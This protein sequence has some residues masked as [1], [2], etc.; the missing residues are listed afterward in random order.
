MSELVQ[1]RQ[2]IKA[3]ETIKKITHAMRIISMST[4][5]RLRAQ[6]S[7]LEEYK[8]TLKSLFHI[9]QEKMTSDDQQTTEP[10]PINKKNLLIIVSSQKGLCGNFNNIL[11]DFFE[12]HYPADNTL[13]IITVGKKADEYIQPRQKPLYKFQDFNTNSVAATARHI[14]E[15]IAST[16]SNYD[17]VTILSNYPK[18]FFVQKP[19]I[20]TVVPLTPTN[21]ELHDKELS[22]EYELEEDANVLLAH[23]KQL[24]MYTTL[25]EA[26]VLSLI[27]EQAARFIAMDNSSR[28]AG[29][30][31][32][33]MKLRYNKTRQAKITRELTDLVGGL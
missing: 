32:D 29:N 33:E 6:Q 23:C 28:N 21:A 19:R 13:E 20:T 12:R 1:L 24:L 11:F 22:G 16:G 17:T 9:I 15:I 25:Y 26:L 10:T 31:L 5:A 3:V 8:T 2:R 18:N 7:S 4:H 14:S 30:I 27:A